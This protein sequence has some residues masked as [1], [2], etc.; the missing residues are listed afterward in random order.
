[1]KLYADHG[2]VLVEN[3]DEDHC[4]TLILNDETGDLA[5]AIMWIEDLDSFVPVTALIQKKS[6]FMDEVRQRWFDEREAMKQ[7]CELTEFKRYRDN[8]E[9]A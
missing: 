1:M 8:A 2:L 5:N 4:Y 3:E 7:E 9:G 6:K